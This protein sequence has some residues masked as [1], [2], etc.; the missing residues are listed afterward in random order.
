MK[1]VKVSVSLK[2]RFRKAKSVKGCEG[3]TLRE[4]AKKL[5]KENDSEAASWFFNKSSKVNKEAKAARLKSKGPRITLEK[6]AKKMARSKKNAT[7]K[8]KSEATSA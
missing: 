8:A 7:S 4:F 3:L 6:A 2:R 1:S 5:V